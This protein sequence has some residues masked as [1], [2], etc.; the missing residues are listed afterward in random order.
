MGATLTVSAMI[1]CMRRWS[2]SRGR[3]AGQPQKRSCAPRRHA[4]ELPKSI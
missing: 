1:S 4:G 3:K 2:S